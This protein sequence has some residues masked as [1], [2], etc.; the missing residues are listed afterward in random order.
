MKM[1]SQEIIAEGMKKLAQNPAMATMGNFANLR[2]AARL[3]WECEE[4]GGE[5]YVQFAYRNGTPIVPP[6]HECH[7][8]EL[9]K[10]GYIDGVGW[11]KD[12]PP[13]P[14]IHLFKWPDGNHWYASV[15][16]KDVVEGKI[17]KWNSEQEAYDA[18]QRFIQN[19]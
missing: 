3:T 9:V 14:K 16:G 5:E 2:I 18:A 6:G 10:R 17:T 19:L 7:P 11:P 15:D 1:T 4:M 8:L 12:G 13:S